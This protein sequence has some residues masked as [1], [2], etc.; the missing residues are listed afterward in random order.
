MTMGGL[1]GNK[2]LSALAWS[3][4]RK[5]SLG[6]SP[7]VIS[8]WFTTNIALA[9]IIFFLLFRR[10]GLFLVFLNAELKVASTSNFA[11]V[12]STLRERNF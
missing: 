9:F 5:V 8:P 7:R 1:A 4:P 10:G 6:F 3:T 2:A 11:A 12:S